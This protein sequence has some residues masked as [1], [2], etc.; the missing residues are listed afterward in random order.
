MAGKRPYSINF[1]R[2][3]TPKPPHL[4][5]FRFLP[6]RDGIVVFFHSLEMPEPIHNHAPDSQ[7]CRSIWPMFNFESLCSKKFSLEILA[8]DDLG[9]SATI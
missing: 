7:V 6:M 3:Q 2:W 5:G 8:G 4:P 9:K 1:G